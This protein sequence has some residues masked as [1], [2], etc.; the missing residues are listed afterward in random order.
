MRVAQMQR[1]ACLWGSAMWKWGG[2]A[3]QKLKELCWGVH[4]GELGPHLSASYFF[5]NVCQQLRLCLPPT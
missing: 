2:I 5:Y 1:W 3:L 4:E